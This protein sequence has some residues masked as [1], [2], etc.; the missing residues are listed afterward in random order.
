MDEDG[1]SGLQAGL[2]RVLAELLGAEQL[3]AAERAPRADTQEE[4]ALTHCFGISASY[5]SSL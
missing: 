5:Q 4:A 3:H 1:K 2:C